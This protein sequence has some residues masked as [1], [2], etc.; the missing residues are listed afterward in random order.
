MILKFFKRGGTDDTRR[1]QGGQAVKDYLLGTDDEPRAGAKLL[2]GNPHDVTE[3]ING[4]TFAKVYTSGCLSF[5]ESDVVTEQQKFDIM[6]DFENM[7]FAGLEPNRYCGYW[8]EHS[9]K[10]RLELNF[11]YLNVD[12]VTG[13]TLQVYYHK[14]DLPL[15][16]AWKDLTNAKYGLKD[17]NALENRRILAPT[18][19]PQ[20]LEAWSESTKPNLHDK[21]QKYQDLDAFKQELTDIILAQALV[22]AE[23]N[24]PLTCQADVAKLIES[25]GFTISRQGK[26]SISIK[27]PKPDQKNIKLKGALYDRQVTQRTI[28]HLA[29]RSNPNPSTNPT[30]E[31][32]E[33]PSLSRQQDVYQRE[34]HKR[35]ERLK[36]RHG[37][38]TQ[39][40]NLPQPSHDQPAQPTANR[41]EQTQHRHSPAEPNGF[42]PSD[43]R[44]DPTPNPYQSNQWADTTSHQATGD[45]QSSP[46]PNDRG[47]STPS[48]LGRPSP[49]LNPQQSIAPSPTPWDSKRTPANLSSDE[50]QKPRTQ[51]KYQYLS[52][53][54]DAINRLN[55]LY[56]RWYL[57]DYFGIGG[58]NGH[59]L[60]RMA[61][62]R[63]SSGHQEPT[64]GANH[65]KNRQIPQRAETTHPYPSQE[66]SRRGDGRIQPTD[67]GQYHDHQRQTTT[68]ALANATSP[69]EQINQ[70]L[71]ET[72]EQPTIAQSTHQ[73][74]TTDY[75]NLKQTI[76]RFSQANEANADPAT[77][78][79]ADPYRQPISSN[80]QRVIQTAIG[81]TLDTLEPTTNR[82]NQQ[83]Q[84]TNQRLLERIKQATE[85]R[86]SNT[87]IRQGR[88]RKLAKQTPTS[89]DQIG[90]IA[91]QR[92][93]QHTAIAGE[94]TKISKKVG[95]IHAKQQQRTADLK[96]TNQRLDQ[97]KDDY[98]E[99][100]NDL[101]NTANGIQC[102]FG[103]A[104]DIGL[105]FKEKLTTAFGKLAKDIKGMDLVDMQTNKKLSTKQKEELIYSHPFSLSWYD[106]LRSEMKQWKKRKAYENTP[107][108]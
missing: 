42:E 11:V 52:P 66:L 104:K 2:L 80:H 94:L 12:L 14:R 53:R 74:P 24:I 78:R 103:T 3:I 47:A 21:L 22:K 34:Y 91:N 84:P 35:Q 33:R 37:D 82:T 26:D 87:Q 93:N 69:T 107:R 105:A 101:T 68:T 23:Q 27:N 44:A 102:L 70:L 98:A 8:V 75:R 108:F 36:Q 31:P 65:P 56:V 9:D 48:H 16:D 90:A 86:D 39:R 6:A 64:T 4:L 72:H 54:Q 51:Q 5:D 45:G 46:H 62:N 71:G 73:Q 100:A 97:L 41:H 106:F 89:L 83:P 85:V 7:L 10:G 19:A 15:V 43:G 67:Q 25:F 49:N 60:S 92:L 95:T 76:E 79:T 17:P 18:L 50:R 57:Y 55:G 40:F 59:E 77:Q 20:I 29:Q 28:E 96:P 88:I 61:G 58:V 13:K 1:S 81:S 63:S 99:N 38:P 30:A 32:A